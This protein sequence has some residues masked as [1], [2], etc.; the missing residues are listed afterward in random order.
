MQLTLIESKEPVEI[1][2]RHQHD[3]LPGPEQ[4]ANPP[5]L[6]AQSVDVQI[7][8]QPKAEM[9]VQVNL[10]SGELHLIGQGGSWMIDE[11]RTADELRLTLYSKVIRSWREDFP[12]DA[13]IPEAETLL[14]RLES[15]KER[16]GSQDMQEQAPGMSTNEED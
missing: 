6:A 4:A 5:L 10:G 3:E 1:E 11:S 14:V 13:L 12:A 9:K 2:F 8:G 15:E 7:P 16:L